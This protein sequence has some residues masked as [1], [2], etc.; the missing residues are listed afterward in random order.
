M[1]PS[2]NDIITE[3]NQHFAGLVVGA[4]LYG[5]A[6]S[7]ARGN[8]VLPN[9]QG[10]YVGL[11]DVYPAIIYHKLNTMVSNIR[12]TNSYGDTIADVVN[13]YGLSMVIYNQSNRTCLSNEDLM[14]LIQANMPELL[15]NEHYKSVSARV[16][17]AVF[18]DAA[19]YQQEYQNSDYRLG[20]NHGLMQINYQLETVFKKGCFINC[21]EDLKCKN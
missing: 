2:L 12:Q 7:T 6:K 13:T 8:E 16:T 10:V 9:V 5:I 1:T 15:T 3:L 19:V 18:D 4:K 20:E 11:D 21:P 17:S 14:L